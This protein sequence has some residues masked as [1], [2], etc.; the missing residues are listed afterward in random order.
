MSKAR[1]FISYSHEDEDWKDSVSGQLSVLN[2]VFDVWDDRRITAGDDWQAEI[3]SALAD[4]DVALLLISRDFLNSAYIKENEV[5]ALLRRR[6]QEGLRVIPVILRP[7]PWQRVNWLNSIQARP[8]DGEALSG[9]REHDQE[10]ALSNLA[11]EIADLVATRAAERPERPTS[12]RLEDISPRDVSGESGVPGI[13][14]E[15]HRLLRACGEEPTWNAV[16]ERFK[17]GLGRQAFVDALM[18]DDDP[19]G[20]LLDL[21]MALENFDVIAA[22]QCVIDAIVLSTLLLYARHHSLHAGVGDGIAAADLLLAAVQATAREGTDAVIRGDDVPDRDIAN[23]AL[24]PAHIQPYLVHGPLDSDWEAIKRALNWTAEALLA[25]LGDGELSQRAMRARFNARHGVYRERHAG[26]SDADLDTKLKRVEQRIGGR[27]V[28]FVSDDDEDEW[29]QEHSERIEN[30][31]GVK[32]VRWRRSH[33]TSGAAGQVEEIF[34][35]LF[36]HDEGLD[37]GSAGGSPSSSWDQADAALDRT[38]ATLER[39][40]RF[41]RL[42]GILWKLFGG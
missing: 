36:P 28:F 6:E 40:A 24:L 18:A 37:D 8:L 22:S 21:R 5:P 31:F 32:T 41:A 34:D 7:C 19:Y 15:L 4:C 13:E 27:I 14:R 17:P 1:I 42:A 26:I 16:V 38:N 11:G 29:V 35:V 30:A 25:A 39:G 12:G 3:T 20:A 23:R 2:A 9:M 10:M 33:E